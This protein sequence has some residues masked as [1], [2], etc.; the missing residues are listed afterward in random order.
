M[1]K[2]RAKIIISV[3][4]Y[5]IM[6]ITII[7]G[8][9][10]SFEVKNRK[11]R[12]SETYGNLSYVDPYADFNLFDMNLDN[13]EFYSDE[14]LRYFNTSFPVKN[15]EFDAENNHYNLL[16]NNSPANAEQ[17][18][19]GFLVADYDLYFQNLNGEIVGS[20]TMNFV[21]KVYVSKIDLEV[22]V[23][24]NEEDFGYLLEYI[25]VNGLKLRII[26]EQ[27]RKESTINRYIPIT[28]ASITV[29][30][31]EPY[32]V[33]STYA[34]NKPGFIEVKYN[35]IVLTENVDYIVQ[36]SEDENDYMQEKVTIT[37]IG[38]Y[39]GSVTKTYEIPNPD[40]YQ[41]IDLTESKEVLT[42]IT[43]LINSSNETGV[44]N[45]CP[46]S[47]NLSI[48][49]SGGKVVIYFDKKVYDSFKTKKRVYYSGISKHK[50]WYEFNELNSEPL[51]ANIEFSL[52]G[53]I[54]TREIP[55]DGSGS[56]I[57]DEN[58][59]FQIIDTFNETQR[60]PNNNTTYGYVEEEFTYVR[61]KIEI[62]NKMSLIGS[63]LFGQI[64]KYDGYIKFNYIYQKHP[65]KCESMET[66]IFN[67]GGNIDNQGNANLENIVFELN[68]EQNYYEE[69]LWDMVGTPDL[70]QVE[71]EILINYQEQEFTITQNLKNKV[72][73][74]LDNTLVYL[75]FYA[76]NQTL[77][78]QV[79]TDNMEILD[80]LTI[81]I[82][83]LTFT[84]QNPNEVCLLFLVY[85]PILEDY[86]IYNNQILNNNNSFVM[87][88]APE[89]LGQTF[90]GWSIDGEN[91]VN[92]DTLS[93]TQ[94]TKFYAL[95]DD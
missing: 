86:V 54:E 34:Y 43:G 19:Y 28:T 56:Y 4:I 77:S 58:F 49:K 62:S 82:N 38:K 1:I 18:S 83:N 39:T 50:V 14:E 65:S 64:F 69:F 72:I 53:G 41:R 91:V 76:Q 3:I 55:C 90:L 73:L 40:Y 52:G 8:V 9:Y 79:N 59:K 84:P 23:N 61:C 32:N 33:N 48:E 51:L 94:N 13:I 93:I 67:G 81:T 36:C 89:M 45:Y 31:L 70:S 27:Y 78:L 87:P 46:G 57:G 92:F 75:D 26:E 21:V 5:L 60:V 11:L 66:A 6:T 85:L 25:K 42:S 80:D 15:V 88:D 63:F 30:E 17:S 68:A 2:D 71:N 22:K 74:E 12:T 95:F 44:S 24:A 37:G 10:L 20:V 47:S 16:V 7:V 35:N 29:D